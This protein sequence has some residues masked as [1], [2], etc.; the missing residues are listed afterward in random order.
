MNSIEMCSH[1]KIYSKYLKF[2]TCS[3]GLGWVFP[4][5]HIS[6][7]HRLIF[8]LLYPKTFIES[9][10]QLNLREKYMY[11]SSLTFMGYNSS[12]LGTKCVGNIRDFGRGNSVCVHACSVNSRVNVMHEQVEVRDHFICVKY[13]PLWKV[14][15]WL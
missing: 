7:E 6:S 14:T 13:K 12:F 15:G 4:P 11:L 1:W 3:V 10:L 5:S 2:A 9:Q 8:G